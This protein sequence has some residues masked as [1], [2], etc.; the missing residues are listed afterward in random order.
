MRIILE[1]LLAVLIVACLVSYALA[2]GTQRNII[3]IS[4]V[5]LTFI[6][7]YILNNESPP[8]A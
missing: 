5:L 3:G 2:H 8:S 4:S 7:I 6:L 1:I